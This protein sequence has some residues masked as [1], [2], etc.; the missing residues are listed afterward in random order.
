M[1]F[2][3]YIAISKATQRDIVKSGIN[4]SLVTTVYPLFNDYNFWKKKKSKSYGSSETKTFLYYGRPGK[5]K[6][7][8]V[9]LKAINKLSNIDDIKINFKLILSKDPIRNRKKINQYIENNKLGD[10]VE[11]EES[12]PLKELRKSLLDSYCVIVPSL[13]EGF[14]YSAYQAC[15]LGK[16]IIT[17]DAGSLPEVIFGK[18]IVFKNGNDDSL[19]RAIIKASEGK[20]SNRPQLIKGDQTAKVINLYRGLLS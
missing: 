6:G 17:S 16:N 9:L 18:T 7:I 20:Y 1:K 15:L 13:T 5:T 3:R 11:V 19:V 4:K 12:K 8:Y 2:S 10:L 14:G